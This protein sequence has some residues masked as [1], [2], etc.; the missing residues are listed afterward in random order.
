MLK[1]THTTL[2]AS[3]VTT[4]TL[5]AGDSLFAYLELVNRDGAAEVTVL[6]ATNGE[7]PSN[8]TA[9]AA[10]TIV[11]PAVAGYTRVVPVATGDLSVKCISAGTPK[12]SVSAYDEHP[13]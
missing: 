2:V 1:S 11:L 5:D 6:Y 12:V 13:G 8:P 10:D 4:V 7:V 9:L 3:T